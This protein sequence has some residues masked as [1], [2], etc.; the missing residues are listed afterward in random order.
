L[1]WALVAQ[2]RFDEAED[3]MR[4]VLEMD[5][6]HRFA[7]ANLS[8]LLFRRG[9]F[10]EAERMYRRAWE[11][12]HPENSI[13]TGLFDTLCLALALQRLERW[14][15][16]RVIVEDEID[17]V[18]RL[19]AERPLEPGEIAYRAGLLA[20]AGRAREAAS[21][22]VKLASI[23]DLDPDS[24]V[25]MARGYALAGDPDRAEDLLAKALEAGFNDPY[26][27]LIDPTFA[28]LQSRPAMEELA[29]VG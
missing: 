2:R 25:T 10:E 22:L 27:L 4:R 12:S 28:G 24:L 21:M 7:R 1:A 14:S 29:P 15:E 6:N 11:I 17:V 5:P 18:R 8:H 20:T 16:A 26:Y 23:D 19:A 13:E 3:L 9:A